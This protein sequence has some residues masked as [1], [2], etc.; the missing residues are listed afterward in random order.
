MRRRN[1]FGAVKTRGTSG[2]LF[3]S[4]AERDR[5]E[6]L[7]LLERAGEIR[8]LVEQPRVELEPGIRFKPDF[9]YVERGRLVHEDVKGVETERFR[10]IKK[11]WRLHGPSVLRITKRRSRKAGFQ[12]TQEIAGGGA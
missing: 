9:S 6:E 11:L 7:M 2:R 10:L 5:A 12:V 4:K 1:K 8:D 3:D